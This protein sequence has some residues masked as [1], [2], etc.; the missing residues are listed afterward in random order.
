MNA[1]IE[2]SGVRSVE[3]RERFWRELGEAIETVTAEQRALADHIC[4]DSM[5]SGKDLVPY[6]LR[7]LLPPDG[8]ID[9]RSQE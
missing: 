1:R 6:R 9:D 2:G 8:V 3:E 7:S 4:G 5:R